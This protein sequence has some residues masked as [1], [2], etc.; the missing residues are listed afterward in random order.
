MANDK[1][2][3]LHNQ[4]DMALSLLPLVLICLAFAGAASMCSV[5]PFG[6]KQGPVPD[7]D[8]DA[9]LVSDA[10]TLSF[11]IRNPHVPDSW[12]PNSGGRTTIT[13]EGGGEVSTVGY[14][15]DDGRYVQLSQTDATEEALV[16]AMVGKRAASG[17]EQ[18]DGRTWVVY[19]EQGSEP[20]WAT[21]LGGVRV[22][23]RGSGSTED[24]TEL[25]DAVSEAPPLDR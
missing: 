22:L 13:E 12:K 9:A 3:I 1:P 15:T 11:P 21:D 16:P 8:I 25:A 4:R 20:A 14:I 10:S 5:A 6:A 19:A 2:R 7:F 24:F 18:I 17:A 23:I